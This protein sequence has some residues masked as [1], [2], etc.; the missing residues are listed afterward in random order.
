MFIILDFPPLFYFHDEEQNHIEINDDSRENNSRLELPPNYS[1]L[2][3][4]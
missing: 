4:F 2:T 3:Y 1:F